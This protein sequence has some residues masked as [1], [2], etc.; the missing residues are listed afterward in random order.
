[1]AANSLNNPNSRSSLNLRSL[2]TTNLLSRRLIKRASN[3]RPG[4]DNNFDINNYKQDFNWITDNSPVEAPNEIFND[5]KNCNELSRYTRNTRRNS[6][7]FNRQISFEEPPSNLNKLFS[8]SSVPGVRDIAG[9]RSL[10]R[11]IFWLI[12]FF[13]FSVLALKDISQLVSEYYGYP[14]T[15][16][17]RLRDSR[18]LLFPAITVCNL[19]IVRYSALCNTSISV[20]NDSMIPQ[21]LKDKLCGIQATVERPVTPVRN[22]IN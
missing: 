9:A 4:Y 14:I 8:E 3:Q 17:V 19:N 21:D 6:R 18:R 10:V 5:P 16:D 1:M 20:I 7:Q 13:F 12:S 11:K 22:S 2:A 15:V